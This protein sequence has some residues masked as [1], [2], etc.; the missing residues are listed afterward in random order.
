MLG[1]QLV[2]GSAIVGKLSMQMLQVIMD[3][4][5]HF[6]MIKAEDIGCVQ[7]KTPWAE[8]VLITKSELE[9]KKQRMSELELQVNE[10]TMQTEYQL[11]LKDLHMQEKVKELTDKFTSEIDN[12]KQKFD[13][14]LQVCFK[15]MEPVPIK[16][17]TS[18]SD[19]FCFNASYEITAEALQW[20]WVFIFWTFAG[21]K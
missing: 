9:E 15:Y 12:E 21:K 4:I 7:E 17:L 16:Y 19:H 20:F 5:L 10:L 6:C 1:V 14:L 2:S 8:E 18:F 11:R 13:L 3:V